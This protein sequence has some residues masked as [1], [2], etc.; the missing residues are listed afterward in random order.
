MV[1]AHVDYSFYVVV[2]KGVEYRLALLAIL[3]KTRIF[4]HAELMR[5]SRHAHRELFG[6]VAYAH[7]TLKEKIQYLDARAVADHREKLGKLKEMLV[8]G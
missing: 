5:Y 1:N 6:N 7:F 8:I 3:D 2:V 4:E